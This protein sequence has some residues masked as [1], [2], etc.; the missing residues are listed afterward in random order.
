MLTASSNWRMHTLTNA[1]PKRSKIRGSL[2][3]NIQRQTLLQHW[4]VWA[5][6]HQPLIIH[7]LLTRTTACTNTC[8]STWQYIR[9]GY[10]NLTVN[11]IGSGP[12]DC[13]YDLCPFHSPCMTVMSIRQYIQQRYVHETVHTTGLCLLDS[14]YNS[15]MS[16]RQYIQQCYVH[17]TV[18]T[19]GLCPWD[20]TYDR[21]MSMRQYI[22]QGYVHETVHTTGLCPWDSTYDRVMSMRVQG[23]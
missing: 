6:I 3:C 21:V 12:F 10:V 11:M 9:Q 7:R 16:M 18:H 19:T 23:C 17:E 8:L 20:S 1:E 14:T 13:P 15:V 22:R 4:P 2:N 5:L